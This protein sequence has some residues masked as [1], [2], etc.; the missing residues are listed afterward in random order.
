[1]INDIYDIVQLILENK[2]ETIQMH[3]T[4]AYDQQT[5][6]YKSNIF[7]KI[8]IVKKNS[9][10]K[11]I[12]EEYYHDLVKITNSEDSIFYIKKRTRLVAFEKCIIIFNITQIIE[13]NQ[14]PLLNK[15]DHTEI[16][17]LTIY[18]FENFDLVVR[19]LNPNEFTIYL[20]FNKNNYILQNLQNELN[21]ITKNLLT[22]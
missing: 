1:M 16:K 8:N 14:F 11:S 3:F 7:E 21:N 20:E 2:T 9:K 12:K 22:D 19:E 13:E 15:Y 10:T 18:Q 6:S 5:H 17:N 4:N